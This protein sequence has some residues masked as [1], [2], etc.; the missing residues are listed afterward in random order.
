MAVKHD[1]VRGPR[2]AA[3]AV[4]VGDAFARREVTWR[5]QLHNRSNLNSERQIE[6]AAENPT[7]A[8]IVGH[9]PE[10]VRC[11]NVEQ[12][13]GRGSETRGGTVVADCTRQYV[14][15]VQ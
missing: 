15:R 7:V 14:A 8:L 5:S 3:E 6:Q 12:I 1:V 11:E 2:S 10:V 9:V 4:H 13:R